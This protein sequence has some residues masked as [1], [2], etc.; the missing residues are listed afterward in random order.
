MGVA[1]L[2]MVAPPLAGGPGAGHRTV[3]REVLV[4]LLEQ[5]TVMEALTALV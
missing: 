4:V 3:G 2:L 1:T 5:G